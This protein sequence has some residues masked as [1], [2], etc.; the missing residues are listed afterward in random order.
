MTG[1]IGIGKT[2]FAD[3]CLLYMLY[4]LLCLKDPYLYYGM[5]PIDKISVSFMNVTIENAKGV[6][7]DK[8]NQLILASPWFMSHGQ[9][10]GTANLIFRP[11][12]HIELIAASSNN[13]II[14]RAL[15]CLDGDTVIK[16]TTGDNK[17]K[18]LVD[19]DIEVIS[20]NDFG[21]EVVS[22]H[23]TVK[24]T[25]LSSEEYEIEL[26]D[27]TMIHCT[28]NHR[29]ML[30]DGSYKEAQNLTEN[31]E[32]AE[33]YMQTYT[34]F[35]NHIIETRGQWNI[36][37]GEYWEGHHILPKCLGGDGNTK[38]KHNNIIRLYP[39]EHYLAHKLL[40]M[41]Y[42]NI[43]SLVNAWEMMI[44][45]KGKTKRS[46][47]ISAD[48]YA[49]ARKLWSTIMSQDNPGCKKTG[50]P[51]NYGLRKEKPAKIKR[52]GNKG[53]IA[54]TN[55]IITKYILPNEEIPA[56]F[57]KGMHTK[58]MSHN[59]IMSDELR[60]TKSKLASGSNNPM[61][62]N[63]AKI[64]GG[65]NGHA[66]IRYFY[67]GQIFECRND[68]LTVLINIDNRISKSTIRKLING[69]T[70]VL[71]EHP[72]LKEVTWEVKSNENKIN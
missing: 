20:I 6:A 1:A 27:G 3:I 35:I 43:K 21:E 63:G 54:I 48:D 7:L 23:C 47:P 50:H 69:S 58:G 72:V 16:T 52:T 68:L 12:K 9:M 30:K 11:E 59:L 70:R 36:P 49:T 13:Q 32:L 14:G 31:D 65:N 5:Q 2:L 45:P 57:T 39:E 28:P 51:W 10:A 56:G 29:F 8:M 55:G 62:Q 64:S 33:G 66:V 15:F 34:S 26:E 25:I 61:Y 41:E 37:E 67:A 4:R 17:L 53:K 22:G 18:D 19:K 46:Y 71:R 38:A 24:P 40:A 44:Y 60:A 42:S